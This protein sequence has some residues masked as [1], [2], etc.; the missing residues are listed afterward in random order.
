[1]GQFYF[2]VEAISL[3]KRFPG[4]WIP[5]DILSDPCV[6]SKL[7]DLKDFQALFLTLL[8]Y[9]GSDV[10]LQRNCGVVV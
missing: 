8:F 2:P 9:A 10:L 5:S 6:H 7:E 3:L 4:L 1:M